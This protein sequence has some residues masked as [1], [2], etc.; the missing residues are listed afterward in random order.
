MKTISPKLVAFTLFVICSLANSEAAHSQQSVTLPF[1]PS[2]G[3][4]VEYVVRRETQGPYMP[5]PS[6]LRQRLTWTDDGGS[7]LLTIETLDVSNANGTIHPDDDFILPAGAS[8]NVLALASPIA[9]QVDGKGAMVSIVRWNEFLGDVRERITGQFGFLPESIRPR[10]QTA[11]NEVLAS[12][13]T[14]GPAGSMMTLGDP[15]ISFFGYGGRVMNLS[16]DHV[17]TYS[18]S[19]F[20][21]ERTVATQ[22]IDRVE[23]L[24]DGAIKMTRQQRTN[25]EDFVAALAET[26]AEEQNLSA[27]ALAERQMLLQVDRIAEVEHI[28]EADGMIRFARW[29]VR[30]VEADGNVFSSNRVIVER[31]ARA[32]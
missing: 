26:Q 22:N 9:F 10:L 27:D 12:L 4:P 30:H 32:P 20:G 13:A 28:I 15:W 1:A 7:L 31:V 17:S 18:Y 11:Y 21:G 5:A 8:R 29:E 14:A 16:Q 25:R 6:T 23:M 3:E 2:I 19:M 24:P